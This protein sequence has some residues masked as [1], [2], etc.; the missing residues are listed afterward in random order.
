MKKKVKKW[1]FIHADTYS[2]LKLSKKADLLFCFRF[3]LHFQKGDRA[4]IYRQAANILKKKGLLVFEAMNGKNS[5]SGKKD[6]GEKRYFI[7]D[8][9]YDKPELFLEL[10][11]NGFKIIRLYPVLKHFKTQAILSAP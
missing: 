9:L 4:K 7:Y 1:K 5:P 6:I 2:Q 11:Q 10:E 3:L 8:H